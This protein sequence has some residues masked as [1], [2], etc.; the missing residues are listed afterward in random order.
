MCGII[1]IIVKGE[2]VIVGQSLVDVLTILQ[3]RGQDAAGIVTCR[4]KSGKLNML[5]NVGPVSE[6]FTQKNVASLTG[7]MGI[8]NK[9]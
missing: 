8:G 9:Y 1:A 3:H 5:K 2:D 7:N 4:S 6:E